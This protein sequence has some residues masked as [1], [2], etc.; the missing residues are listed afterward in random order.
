[1]EKKARKYTVSCW[2]RVQGDIAVYADN[3]E[4]AMR[5]A[6]EKSADR[7]AAWE[8]D[9]KVCGVLTL[10]DEMSDERSVLVLDHD[11]DFCR[12][13]EIVRFAKRDETIWA[14]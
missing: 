11:D 3:E 7:L 8:A 2:C 13:R 5:L 6:Y 14:D 4:D 10:D 12:L 9:R 1:M